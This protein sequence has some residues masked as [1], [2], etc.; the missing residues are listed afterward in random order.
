MKEV[1]EALRLWD[2]ADAHVQPVAH[3][4]NNI[5]LMKYGGSDFALRLHRK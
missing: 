4:E 1:A 5:F 2:M 3:R